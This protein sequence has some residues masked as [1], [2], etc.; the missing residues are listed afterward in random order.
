MF[1]MWKVL[2]FPVEHT[3]FSML[4]SIS[5]FYAIIL[6]EDIGETSSNIPWELETI[7]LD[8]LSIEDDCILS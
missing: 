5:D 1:F 6:H 3:I 8:K 2:I 7:Y 4:C